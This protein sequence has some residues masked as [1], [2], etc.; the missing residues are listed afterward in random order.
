MASRKDDADTKP[1]IVLHWL[2]VSRSHRIL[3]LLEEIGIPYELKLYKRTAAGLAPP[4]LKQVHPLGKS[5]VVTILPHGA[6][7]PI[8]LAE[9]AAIVEYLC[10]YY[11]K[12]LTPPRYVGGK[13]GQI[14][15]ESESW[16]RFR[17]LMNYAEGSLMPI[18]LLALVVQ[19]IRDASV[20][21]FIKPITNGV[22]N[23]IASGF[24]TPSLITHYDFLEQ[25]LKTSPS[26]GEFF[27]GKDL[28]AADMML[29][30]PLEAGRTRSG[31][32]P[33]NYPLIWAWV[34]RIHQQDSYKRATQKIVD[35]DRS[36]T[37]GF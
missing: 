7:E 15:G 37:T 18:L 6:T 21:F 4:E 35:I 27:C 23:K 14:G 12:W 34:D 36:F 8:V 31:M 29:S 24:V 22:A 2:E 9:S 20:P 10:D 1:K 19:K 3:W 30:F 32:S 26:K 25:Q 28:T 13:E 33:E 5:P 11:G 17:M 16:I